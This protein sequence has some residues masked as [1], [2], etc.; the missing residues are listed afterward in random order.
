M[1]VTA[2]CVAIDLVESDGSRQWS[3]HLHVSGLTGDVGKFARY[4]LK[5]SKNYVSLGI[6]NLRNNNKSFSPL[7]MYDLNTRGRRGIFGVSKMLSDFRR[8]ILLKKNK[9]IN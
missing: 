5:T 8:N 9:L 7:Y 3:H 1:K 6:F 2:A 4:H